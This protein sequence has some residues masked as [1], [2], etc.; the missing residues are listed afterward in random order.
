ML[1]NF[2][3]PLSTFH[4]NLNIFSFLDQLKFNGDISKIFV[5][6]VNVNNYNQNTYQFWQY[7]A[8][9]ERKQAKKYYLSYLSD[10]YIISH[11]ILRCILGYYTRQLPQ[12]IQFSYN[13]YEKPFLKD[14]NIQFN[15]SHSHE[16]VSYVIAWNNHVGIDI[17]LC[18][19]SLD[20]QELSDLVFTPAEY[21]FF[22]TLE[23]KEK[24]IF[25][26][27]I[28]TKKESLIKANGSG[29]S[30]P[31]NTIDTMVALPDA[32]ILLTSED[33]KHKKEWYSFPL[34]VTENY[35]GAI[36]AEHKINQIVYHILDKMSLEWLH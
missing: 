4:N 32:K 1:I 24:H 8:T 10:R 35:L 36:A 15:M 27:N 2:I 18:D 28:W 31:I 20:I 30:Y 26:Y 14:H 19:Y 33:N 17:E 13:K 5:Y 25:F 21:T 22:S 29:M 12:D 6:I 23:T 3:T 9:Q 34:E 11:G 16:L 7:L